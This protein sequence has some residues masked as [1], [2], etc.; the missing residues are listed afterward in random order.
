LES[1]TTDGSKANGATAF[2]AT[3]AIMVSA[4]V[5][6]GAFGDSDLS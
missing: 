2:P 4:E 5:F 3:A 1:V 6:D